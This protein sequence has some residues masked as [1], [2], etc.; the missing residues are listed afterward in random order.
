[1]EKRKK[2]KGRKCILRGFHKKGHHHGKGYA[3]S[4]IGCEGTVGDYFVWNKDKAC[5][6]GDITVQGTPLFAQVFITWLK[7]K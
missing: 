4:M 1:M 3:R 6:V 7:E 5:F 2:Y